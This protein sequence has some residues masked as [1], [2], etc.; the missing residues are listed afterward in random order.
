MKRIIKEGKDMFNLQANAFDIA[1][2][3]QED[4]DMQIM[5][6]GMKVIGFQIMSFNYPKEVRDM[7][8]K[9]ASHG[10]I[11]DISKYQQ[12]SMT[13]CSMASGK[14][15]GSRTASD[16]A[17]MMMGMNMANE[18]LKNVSKNKPDNNESQFN[19]Q[20][21]AKPKESDKK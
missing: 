4:L 13:N 17:S 1:R 6:D 21:Q 10:M 14:V 16:M 5:D 9:T 8:T 19:Q 3:I 11:E 20:Q 15:S 12:V 18:M 2:S 7:I